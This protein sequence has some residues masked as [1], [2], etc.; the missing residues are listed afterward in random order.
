MNP[1]KTVTRFLDTM[2]RKTRWVLFFPVGIM[3]SIFFVDLV[4]AGFN[5]YYG[6]PRTVPGLIE[7]STLA[8]LAALTRTLFPAVISPRPWLVGL[9]MFALDFLLRAGPYAYQLMSYEYMRYRAPEIY[10][11]VAAGTVG[12]LIGLLLVRVVMNTAKPRD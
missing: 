12:G 6:N 11:Y 2:P 8:F 9:I 4:N 1:I 7:L 5:A 3:A 10:R